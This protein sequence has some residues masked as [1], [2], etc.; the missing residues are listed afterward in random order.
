MNHAHFRQQRTKAPYRE[1]LPLGRCVADA[2]QGGTLSHVS[3]T[4]A[5][6]QPRTQRSSRTRRVV[7][8][9]SL[10]TA[11]ALVALANMTH[12]PGTSIDLTTGVGAEGPGP[13]FNTLGEFEGK[14]IVSVDGAATH[15]TT[16]QL[17]MTTVAVRSNMTLAQTL[18]RWLVEGDT[19]ISLKDLYPEGMSEQE[20]NELN[21][22]AFAQSE[23]SATFAA[24]NYLNYPLQVEVADVV[25]DAPV[26]GEMQAGDI[27]DSINNNTVRT[28]VEVVHAVR[29]HKP[30]D[31]LNVGFTRDGQQR[32][33]NIK[34]ESNPQDPDVAWLG[35]LLSPKTLDNISVD[36]NLENIG[37]PSAGMMFALAVVDKL[38]AEEITGGKYIAGTGTIEADGSVGP[39]G[40]ITHKMKTVSE[41]GAEV[42]LAPA[43][44]CDEVAHA[45]KKDK[46]DMAIIKVNTLKDAVDGLKAYNEGKPYATCEAS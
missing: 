8:A 24:L 10:T 45:S 6:P 18:N 46:G 35:V 32:D 12:I 9:T 39:I 26:A 20:V 27:I 42:F 34:L 4:V 5:Q 2:H 11:L 30:G 21:Q 17:N 23:N 43:D 3:N 29:D 37:G 19:L 25:K 28:P 31:T 13:T 44:N 14:E 40:G 16:G 22:H 33:V 38:T 7:I 15:P 36:Y 41:D 1:A